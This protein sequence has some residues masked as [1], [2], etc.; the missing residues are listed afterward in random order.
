MK[1]GVEISVGEIFCVAY[2]NLFICVLVSL[3][4]LNTPA[5]EFALIYIYEYIFGWQKNG[6]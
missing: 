4:H 5:D 3:F 1:I 2:V 6:W